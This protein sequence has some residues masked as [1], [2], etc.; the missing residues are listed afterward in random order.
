VTHLGEF[1]TLGGLRT[2]V[3]SAPDRRAYTRFRDWRHGGLLLRFDVDFDLRSAPVVAR[4]L[5]DV[6]VPAT[7]FV[8]T[9]ADTYNVTSARSRARLAE[10]AALGF[11]VGLHFDPTVYPDADE[12]TLAA[13]MNA[14]RHVLAASA[15]V[16]VH[17]V[18]LH[19][20]SVHGTYPMF[21]GVVNAY[22]PVLF[23]DRYYLSDSRRSFRGKDPF[24]FLA[25]VTDGAARQIV[26]H[27]EHYVT[28]GGAGYQGMVRR[29]LLAT[30][31]EIDE[32]FEVNSTYVSERGGASSRSLNL[33]AGASPQTAT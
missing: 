8:L 6:D 30:C 29:Y 22:D 10:I 26:L 9:S 12:E 19:N 5:A 25:G 17:S 16:E 3:Q 32:M 20:P 14:E 23:V 21:D 1:F 28:D 15:G 33:R 27:P 2:F 13:R 18:S 7:F 24:A 11:E 4:I 31:D